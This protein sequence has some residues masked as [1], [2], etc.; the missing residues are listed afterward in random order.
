MPSIYSP[1]P[2]VTND[3]GAVTLGFE[4]A[5]NVL[6]DRTMTGNTVYTISTAGTTG[7]ETMSVTL[8]GA[9]QYSFASSVAINWSKQSLPVPACTA[10]LFDRIKF[11]V[12]QDGSLLAAQQ[13]SAA[14]LGVSAPLHYLSESAG[15]NSF[16]YPPNTANEISDGYLDIQARVSF[17]TLASQ[18]IIFSKWDF[19]LSNTSSGSFLFYLN[20][21]GF[22]SVKWY[23]A[24][25][26]TA[27]ASVPLS[28]YYSPYA[29]AWLRVQLNATTS[30]VTSNGAGSA[31]IVIPAGSAVFSISVDG[32]NWTQVGSTISG[33]ATAGIGAGS[34]AIPV[35]GGNDT[36]NIMSGNFYAARMY[37]ASGS[38]RYSPDFTTLLTGQTGTFTDDAASPNTWSI[39]A[40]VI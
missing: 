4:G 34:T 20:A 35:C 26:Q 30:P 32:V 14:C 1:Q 7:G 33:G 39:N 12:L 24:A 21:Q 18:Q 40:T 28:T 8:R 36:I 11:E 13:A 23:D 15:S 29:V 5:P 2:P 19:D 25:V 37:S 9:Y 38:L 27:T 10:V 16:S 22:L 31:V 3:T 6:Y 17:N